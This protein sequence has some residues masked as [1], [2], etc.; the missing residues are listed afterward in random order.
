M[1]LQTFLKL[2][3]VSNLPTVWTNAVAG[4][5]LAG[6]PSFG[7]ILII[8]IA[9]TLFYTGGMWL[10][11]AFDA[12]IDAQERKNRPIPMGEIAVT[13]VFAV[14]YGMLMLGVVLAFTFGA[15][16]GLAGVALAIAVILYDWLH[17]R[18]VL[19]P[20]IMGATR[21]FCYVLAA[22][23]V[24]KVTGSVIF[25]A[26]GLLAYIVGLTY[27]AKQEAY[28]RLDNAWP[29]VVL[30]IPMIYALSQAIGSTVALLIWVG[31]GVVVFIALRLLF[32]RNKG[33]VPRAV[34]TMIAGI[35]LYDAVL[36]AGQGQAALAL[37]AVAGFALTLA[38]QRIVSG[39]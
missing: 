9:L 1:S 19:S 6:Q 5:V 28:D 22:F 11:D 10:N 29:L 18:T 30:A 21:F 15:M 38:L 35:C 14:G 12:E 36:I 16:A 24:A 13:T 37:L 8:G 39:T 4:A 26:L 20:I 17:K 7:A 31:L 34:V 3:R 27:A 23:A 32:R 2:G 33:D 25:G